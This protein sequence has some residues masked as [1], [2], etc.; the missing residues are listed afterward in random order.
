[1]NAWQSRNSSKNI[2]TLLFALGISACGGG[3]SSEPNPPAET[4]NGSQPNASTTGHAPAIRSY[5]TG[6]I[7]ESNAVS[8]V[9]ESIGILS[10]IDE[11]FADY[12]E[13]L[14]PVDPRELTQHDVPGNTISLTEFMCD[15]GGRTDL[16]IENGQMEIDPDSFTYFGAGDKFR[17]EREACASTQLR[18]PYKFHGSVTTEVVSGYYDWFDHFSALNS[19]TFQ[20]F[21]KYGIASADSTDS[22][23]HGDINLKLSEG[24]QISLKGASLRARTSGAYRVE[25]YL[26]DYHL[27]INRVEGLPSYQTAW[28]MTADAPFQL[29]LGSEGLVFNAEINSGIVYDSWLGDVQDGSYTLRS[30]GV[31]LQVEIFSSHLTYKLDL[32]QDGIFEI[33]SML[34]QSEY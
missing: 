11:D 17:I 22:Y 23:I 18:S 12:L 29:G 30:G 6:E 28:S 24:T 21:E 15:L 27:T 5:N 14:E 1:M 19:E 16:I 9:K 2:A 20:V 25:Y 34:N 3:G 4:N 10:R 13:E 31:V 26:G 32:D 8:L 7:T 33:E